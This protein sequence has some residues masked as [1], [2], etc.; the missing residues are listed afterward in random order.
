MVDFSVEDIMHEPLKNV[1]NI[2][3]AN[4]STK[5]GPQCLTIPNVT[6]R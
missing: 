6:L 2:F 3:I 1:R 5:T 4:L